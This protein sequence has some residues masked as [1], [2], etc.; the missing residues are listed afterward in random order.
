MSGNQNK[1][2]DFD[3]QYQMFDQGKKP[4]DLKR[5]SLN[6]LKLNQQTMNMRKS[7]LLFGNPK[8]SMSSHKNDDESI[9]A[10]VS[11]P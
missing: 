3:N 4:I 10:S 5:S 6:P 11:L 7:R 8:S 1:R 2:E 9:R